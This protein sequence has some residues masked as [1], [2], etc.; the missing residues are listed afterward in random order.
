MKNIQQLI[1]NNVIEYRKNK[2]NYKL[3]VPLL[4]M[5]IHGKKT[6]EQMTS[7]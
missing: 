4:V 5:F 1:K 6:L 2:I 7:K 3:E